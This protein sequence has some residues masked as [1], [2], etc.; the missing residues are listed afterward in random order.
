MVGNSVQICEKEGG[1]GR[2]E[3]KSVDDGT[4]KIPKSNSETDTN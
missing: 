2:V 3:S 1:M 4:I